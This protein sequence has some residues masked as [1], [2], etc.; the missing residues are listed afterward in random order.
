[1]RAGSGKETTALQQVRSNSVNY[2]KEVIL[3][4]NPLRAASAKLT[5]AESFDLPSDKHHILVTAHREKIEG[6]EGEVLRFW[7]GSGNHHRLAGIL[8]TGPEGFQK[9]VLFRAEK[10]S[11]FY[12]A[13]KPAAAGLFESVFW[14]AP[15]RSLQPVDFQPATEALE[16]QISA[17]E[18]FLV[19]SLS[20]LFLPE[21][22]IEF[23]LRIAQKQRK[24]CA[25]AEIHGK[26]KMTGAYVFDA[27]KKVYRS[28][29]KLILENFSRTD[30]RQS[31]DSTVV[32]N[33]TTNS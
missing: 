7:V 28:N 1:M 19:P 20:H 32:V 27:R 22:A 17:D 30:L 9:P 3:S 13:N 5:F 21:G 29:Y 25:Q 33:P 12:V 18:I 11:F 26:Y 24:C 8:R 16:T 4:D 2:S 10:Q 14:V 15:D 6:F 31:K 23:A